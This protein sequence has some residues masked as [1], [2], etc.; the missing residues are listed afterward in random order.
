[1]RQAWEV[2]M[3][4]AAVVAAAVAG[5]GGGENLVLPGSAEPAAV[6]ITG[7][8]DQSARV[9]EELP[10]AI[11]A[12]VT[13]ADGRA[14]PGASVV[15][16]LTDPPPGAG[17]DP[18]TAATDADGAVTA[19]VT[20]GT[21]PGPVSGEIR[22]LGTDGDP[23]ATAPFQFT[24]LND[25]ANGISPVSGDGQSAPVG[26]SLPD[27]LVVEVTDAF[28]NPVE[29]VEVAWTADGG[30]TVS[31]SA[32]STGAD[33]RT[34]VTRTLG[35][36]AGTQRTLA[37]VA[38][39][40]GSPV[41]FVHTAT[42]GSAAGVSIVSGDDQQ[43]PAGTALPDPVVVLVQDAESNPVAGVAVAWVIGSGGGSVSPTTSNTGSDGRA[44]TMWTL[45]SAAG[46][47]TLSA[48]VSGIGIAEFSATALAGP[49]ARLSMRTQPSSTATS[50]VPLA[51]QPVIQLL[52]AQGRESRKSGVT[53]TAAIASG[54]GTLGGTTSRAT[55][56]DGR[57]GFTDL[58]LTGEPGSRTL[59]FSAPNLAGVTSSAISLGAATTVTTITEDSPDPSP[60]GSAVTVRFQVTSAAGTPTGTV[61]VSDGGATCSGTLA[62]G[63]GSCQIILATAGSRTLRADY[64]GSGAF[65]ASSG[66]EE[67]TVQ[68]SLPDAGT[69]SL[70]A[71]PE[72][73]T[74]AVST[75]TV[76][77]TVRD[78][79]GA[80]LAGRTVTL[81]SSGSDD[82]ITPNPAATDADGI[83]TF[84]FGAV[85]PG[86]KTLTATVDGVVIGPASILV[87]QVATTTSITGDAPD[88]SEAGAPVEISFLV[89]SALGAPPGRVDVR[90]DHADESCSAG[91]ADGGCVLQ[92][93]GHGT[94]V[95][96][97]SYQ[98]TEQFAPS[99][100]T[101]THEV[102]GGS[103]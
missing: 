45:G 21:R 37:T 63:G 85:T 27:P 20:V 102:A 32:T 25:D 69:S 96:T 75:S 54:G 60:A 34:Q 43:G 23:A 6:T 38:G 65:G 81:A 51:Q 97:A 83:A 5:C 59:G 55:D 84:T 79:T 99:A 88:P 58:V 82:A 19:R 100:G 78:A 28:G 16:V 44:S 57:A 95:L 77:A 68:E 40:A 31:A 33:G 42:A 67:H 9:G 48:V 103:N 15:F 3:V 10:E 36:S 24:A 101:A 91:V 22:A 70:T 62:D 64:P 30:G 50:G 26:S 74:A 52:D 39:L 89:T 18:A 92:L 29:S 86:T 7:G 13:D 35:P 11:V 2:T 72:T 66:T 80:P 94:R 12:T 49:P 53:V 1:M 56:A 17:V 73:I 4:G 61:T 8:N 46:P 98:G 76:T 90:S 71:A 47:N 14:I 41:T 93:R 87:E